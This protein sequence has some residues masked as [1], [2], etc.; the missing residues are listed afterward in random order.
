M[1]ASKFC[2]Y[3]I[4]MFLL[5]IAIVENSSLSLASVAMQRLSR[6]RLFDFGVQRCWNYLFLQIEYPFIHF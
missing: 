3:E 4:E 6:V 1:S 5:K 2:E